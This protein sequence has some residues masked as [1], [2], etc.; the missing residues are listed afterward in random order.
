MG[1]IE[2]L[3]SEIVAGLVPAS[4]AVFV[5]YMTIRDRLKDS[6]NEIKILDKEIKRL[7]PLQNLEHEIKKLEHEI[8]MLEPLKDLLQQ[9]GLDKAEKVFKGEYK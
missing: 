3:G 6:E 5:G 9:V 4:I 1:L 2:T 7:E 8:K